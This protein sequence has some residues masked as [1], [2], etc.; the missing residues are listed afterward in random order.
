MEIMIMKIIWMLFLVF[1]T[2]VHVQIYIRL[3]G[4]VD[5][6]SKQEI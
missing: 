5:S 2:N 4:I 6:F 1:G 3:K